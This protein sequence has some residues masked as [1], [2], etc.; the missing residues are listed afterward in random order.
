MGK[1][2]KNIHW[3]I[4]GLAIFNIF[5]LWSEKSEQITTL[6]DQVT[7]MDN[8]LI[9][10]RKNKIKLQA[11]FKDIDEAKDRIERVAIQI[12]KSQQQLPSDLNDGEII[13]FISRKADELNIREV[14]LS[15]D[16]KD[17]DRGFYSVRKYNLKAKGTYVQFLILFENISEYKRI[18]NVG[19]VKFGRSPGLQRSRFQLIDGEIQILAY[20]YNVGYKEDR[21]IDAINEKLKNKNNP[22][23]NSGNNPTQNNDN[24][25]GA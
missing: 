20:R 1:V 13:G 24:N 19:R 18:L 9:V 5:S 8:D 22:K 21:G 7:A 10:K 14:N 11:F 6:K 23:A 2:L 25:E 12:E 17:E 4:I 16:E 15:P 3:L